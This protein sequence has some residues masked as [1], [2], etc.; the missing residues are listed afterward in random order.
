MD[1]KIE[2]LKFCR[3]IT[4]FPRLKHCKCFLYR[5]FII[6]SFLSLQ[7]VQLSAYGFHILFEFIHLITSTHSMK[8]GKLH[9][10]YFNRFDTL[11]RAICS[12]RS[13]LW[14][15][16]FIVRMSTVNSINM[17]QSLP[18]FTYLWKK[19]NIYTKSFRTV[20]LWS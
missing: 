13:K 10:L 11:F 18:Y 19:S 9:A 4:N 15:V 12:L 6:M 2:G 7:I 8:S 1:K 14:A 20:H 5:Q 17:A 16:R 3:H